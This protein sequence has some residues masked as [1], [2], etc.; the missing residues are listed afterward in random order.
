MEPISISIPEGD[1]L[2]RSEQQLTNLIN[3]TLLTINGFLPKWMSPFKVCELSLGQCPP[4][5]YTLYLDGSP[6]FGALSPPDTPILSDVAKGKFRV[7]YNG[8]S[9]GLSCAICS[10]VAAVHYPS[11]SVNLFNRFCSL[12]SY[13]VS[14]PPGR[15][16]VSVHSLIVELVVEVLMLGHDG[17]TLLV[18]AIDV[19]DFK[20]KTS[21][22]LDFCFNSLK[23]I[24]KKQV[25]S[26]LVGKKFVIP[27]PV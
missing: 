26:R 18:C 17:I 5:L 23:T 27:V 25:R 21:C 14:S 2:I 9:Q 8:L 22:L 3:K 15:F 13:K 6:V 12:G 4:K 16:S 7:S 10:D 19:L 24:L 1:E 11:D 20:L